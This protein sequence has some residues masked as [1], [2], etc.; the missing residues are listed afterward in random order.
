MNGSCTSSEILIINYAGYQVKKAMDMGNK[1]GAECFLFSGVQERQKY[2]LNLE[3]SKD[4]KHY[5]QFLKLILDYKERMGYRTQLLIDCTKK[6]TDDTYFQDPIKMLCFLKHYN[7][8]KNYKINFSPE[9]NYTLLSRYLWYTFV[10]LL[11]FYHLDLDLNGHKY[12]FSIAIDTMV[13][14][15][16]S[17]Q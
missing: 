3:I 17:G 12:L 8:D 9:Q 11:F 10:I 16:S 6:Y 1:L 7:L 15:N 4:V 14:N 5:A 2:T 13:T